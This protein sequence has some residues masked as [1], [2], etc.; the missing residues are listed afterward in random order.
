MA[1][2]F[3][4]VKATFLVTKKEGLSDEEFRK[5]YTDVHAPMAIEVCKRHGALDYSVHFNTEAEKVAAR[6]AFGENAT[7]ISCDAVTTFIFPDMKSLVESFADPEYAAKLAPDEATFTD[8]SKS[9]FAVSN[10][11]V[12]LA[13]GRDSVPS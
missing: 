12:V 9:Q 8:R 13:G 10:E 11:F 5:H 1:G 4:H 2:T 7:F 3:R 6:A